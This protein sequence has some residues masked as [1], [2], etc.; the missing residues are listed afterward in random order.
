MYKALY[1]Q[2]GASQV[3]LAQEPIYF[4]EA[5]RGLELGAGIS[6]GLLGSAG[7]GLSLGTGVTSAQQQRQMQRQQLKQMSRAGVK[8]ASMLGVG[9][10][11]KS[12]AQVA[13]ML[14][15]G[16]AQ[17]QAQT[18]AQ[19][20]VQKLQQKH[21]SLDIKTN[22]KFP[23]LLPE[24]VLKPAKKTKTEEE[25]RKLEHGV[26]LHPIGDISKILMGTTP[27]RKKRGGKQWNI[28]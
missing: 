22:I 20:Q 12:Q 25:L 4:V 13:Q 26:R 23:P 15:V 17:A 21:L 9:T 24:E 11:Q 10:A 7:V 18:Q 19:A 6:R 27:K 5:G 16:V 3:A 8:A 2:R 28:I 14:Q 1:G